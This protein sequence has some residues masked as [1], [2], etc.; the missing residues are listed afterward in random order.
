[1]KRYILILL[2]ILLVSVVLAQQVQISDEKVM[3]DGQKFYLHTV[4]KGHTL[5][6]ISKAYSVDTET[7]ERLNPGVIEG[8]KLGQSL[9]IP[10]VESNLDEPRDEVNFIYHTIK[11]KE[12]VYSL[13]KQ[14]GITEEEFYKYN[15][16]IKKNGLKTGNEVL[17]PRK[18]ASTEFKYD[19]SGQ[20]RDTLKYYY[21]EI[22]E[23]ETLFSLS[24]EYDISRY[25]LKMTNPEVDWNKLKLGQEIAIPIENLNLITWPEATKDSINLE[26]TDSI[27]CSSDS[28]KVLMLLPFNIF[29]NN[30]QLYNQNLQ[31]KELSLYPLS[32]VLLDFYAGTLI[33][34][35]SLKNAG[36]VLSL[37]VE[38]VG[39][40]N[41]IISRLIEEDIIKD[42]NVIIGPIFSD[43]INLVKKEIGETTLI[44][45]PFTECNI[46]DLEQGRLCVSPIE[47]EYYSFVAEYCAN[48]DSNQY[49][50]ISDR[51]DDRVEKIY[52]ELNLA[53]DENDEVT[54]IIKKLAFVE[55]EVKTLQNLM[56]ESLN[57]VVI[58]PAHSEPYIARI[59]SKLSQV[60]DVKIQLIGYEN[61]LHYGS[62]EPRYFS[63]LNFT[64]ASTFNIDY[65]NSEIKD[66]VLKYRETFL[67][68][69]TKYGFLAYD[70]I[71][72]L[73]KLYD[74]NISII[75]GQ[76]PEYIIINGLAANYEFYPYVPGG[77]IVN[78]G[79][80]LYTLSENFRL[81][82]VYPI[83]N[84]NNSVE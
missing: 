14:Y 80:Y 2:A 47:Q 61:W 49:I 13:T 19:F 7:L 65:S 52:S 12:T 40:D 39:N 75:N 79:L 68:E 82:L 81:N 70:I 31:N 5:Y 42:F 60:E 50:I 48:S 58:I 69:P 10:V 21:H 76:N 8:V 41:V 24:R 55:G 77:A 28:L 78:T 22:K 44:V 66:F 63:K 54:P 57:N 32:E 36:A 43:Q 33:A 59:L 15:P 51:I 1:M 25:D 37:R 72:S 16:D 27:I 20:V 83:T 4:E 84:I 64:Y 73:A 45:N 38:D 35:D 34:L 18:Q 9:K 17:I 56:S 6:S 30:K 3:I 11:R 71:I 74:L 62:I 53:F 46:I 29:A 26:L 67:T 23:G